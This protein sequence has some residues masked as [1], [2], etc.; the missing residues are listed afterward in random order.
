M[1][2][3][4]SIPVTRISSASQA[5]PHDYQTKM[6]IVTFLWHRV[7][8]IFSTLLLLV[9]VIALF[10]G[11]RLLTFGQTDD[12]SKITGKQESRTT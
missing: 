3:Q 8:A 9:L 11:Y 12:Q 1:N 7:T 2:V 10:L 4:V 5:G 6:K